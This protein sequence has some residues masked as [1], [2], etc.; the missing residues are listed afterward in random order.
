MKY[1]NPGTHL[2]LEH[3]HLHR[4]LFDLGQ[5]RLLLLP[6]RQEGVRVQLAPGVV[7]GGGVVRL[8]EKRPRLSGVL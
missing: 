8:L 1:W 7:L 5:S 4:V 2:L 6:D 3:H